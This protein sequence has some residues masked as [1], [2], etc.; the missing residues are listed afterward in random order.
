MTILNKRIGILAGM[1]AAAGVLFYDLI[2]K[3]C[4]KRGA[5]CD[6]DFPEMIIYNLNSEAMDKTG[7]T[8]I[9]VLKKQLLK[10]IKLLNWAECETI[11]IAC[12]SAY[13][14]YDYLQEN[15]V[16]KILNMPKITMLKCP[17]NYGVI[18][19]RFSRQHFIYSGLQTTDNEQD[20][21]DC[22]IQNVI[23]GKNNPKDLTDLYMIVKSLFDRGAEKVVLG[24][25]ELY[26]LSDQI[27]LKGKIID[28]SRETIKELFN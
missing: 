16:A 24:C 8:D 1:G 7:V 3:E 9:E 26:I 10:G 5:V 13:I 14:C 18:C 17:E 4:Q 6:S 23:S 15:S 21:A 28:S 25:T 20:K 12:N 27:L 19:S 2:V 22:L 11:L